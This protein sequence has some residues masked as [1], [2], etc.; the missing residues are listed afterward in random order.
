MRIAT[1]AAAMLDVAKILNV[2][3]CLVVRRWLVLVSCTAT[4]GAARITD[5]TGRCKRHR[6]RLILIA[7]RNRSGGDVARPSLDLVRAR[8]GHRVVYKRCD[9]HGDD[10]RRMACSVL[11][12]ILLYGK[13]AQDRC[14]LLLV[15][16]VFDPPLQN[17]PNS[18]MHSLTS[19]SAWALA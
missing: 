13:T 15:R 19:G 18:R 10:E 17:A 16:G 12:P 11:P 3:T 6:R 9:S 5:S 8:Q 7:T 14:L 1:S 4:S 2:H